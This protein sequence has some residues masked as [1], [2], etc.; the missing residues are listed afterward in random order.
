M[1][2]NSSYDHVITAHLIQNSIVTLP[3]LSSTFIDYLIV[4]LK[5][6]GSDAKE[7]EAPRRFGVEQK[8]GRE[9]VF[10]W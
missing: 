2:F 1:I 8:K 6:L 5:R 10:T 3:Q 4:Y 9:K 7:D